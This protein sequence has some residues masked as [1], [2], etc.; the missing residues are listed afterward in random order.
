MKNYEIKNKQIQLHNILYSVTSEQGYEMSR[1]MILENM[2]DTNWNEYVL[3]EGSHC[4][5]YGF[6]D[7][8]WDCIVVTEEEL[9][10]ILENNDC[11]GLRKKAK[12]FIKEYI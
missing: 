11:W 10:K 7:T 5:C 8:E 2:P 6:D 4:S 9:V 3:A 12:E 1:L